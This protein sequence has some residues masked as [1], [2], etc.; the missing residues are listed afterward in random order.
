MGLQKATI[1]CDGYSGSHIFEGFL[2]EEATWRAA[3]GREV[4]CWESRVACFVSYGTDGGLVCG[5]HWKK[6]CLPQR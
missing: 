4:S 3:Q 6:G 2:E 1:R 5:C